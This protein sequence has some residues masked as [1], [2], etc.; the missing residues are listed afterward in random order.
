MESHDNFAFLLPFIFLAFGCSFLLIHR[1]GSVSG[2]HWGLG[3]ISAAFGFCSPLLLAAASDEAQAVVSNAFFFAAFFLYGHA[4]LCRFG[5]SRSL[6]AVRLSTA[7]M[8]QAVVSYFIAVEH[9]LESELITSDMACALLL[10]I[11]LLQVRNR[12]KKPIDRL[13]AGMVWLVVVETAVR[14]T[15]LLVFT[16]GNAYLSL[17]EFLSSDYAFVMQVGA[18]VLGFLL[19]LTVL[20][21]MM[22]DVIAQ[23]RHSAEHDP[24]TDLLN[25]RGFDQA[26]PDFRKDSFPSGAVLACDI[27]LFKQVNDRFG[28]AAGDMVI[29]GLAKVLTELLPSGTLVTRFG[30]EEFVAF[31]PGV[32]L[33][34]GGMLANVVRVSFAD[35]AWDEA[36]ILRQIT[37]SFGVSS[38]A[39]SDHSV[40]DAIGRAD[41]CLYAAKAGGRNQ[42][43]LEDNQALAVPPRLRLVS[44]V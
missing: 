19:A 13:L 18:S 29:V 34:D 11:P 22:L 5:L 7:V 17:D 39:P 3:Y 33:T 38:T 43:V 21:T 32:S 40:H 6:F 4:L 14:V 1:W 12:T 20:G 31:I 37:V 42:V 36:G 10:S 2:I 24:L 28:H 27:D 16:F 15:S 35:K 25:R 8:A 30:G 26:V 44:A 41:L 23:H 9:D